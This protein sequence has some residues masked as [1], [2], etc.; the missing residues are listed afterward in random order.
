MTYD[1]VVVG[2]GL[3]GLT[4]ALRLAEQGQRVAVVARGVGATHLAPA[5]IDVLGYVDEERVESPAASLA[6]LVAAHPE[7]PYARLAPQVVA[8]SLEWLAERAAGLGYAGSLDENLLLPTAAGV[9]KPSALVPETMTGG[10]LRAGDRFLFVGLRGLK[11]FYA[12]YAAD[13]L[14]HAE[15]P[16]PV[17]ARAVELTPPLGREADV[18]SVGFARRFDQPEFRDWIVAA[19]ASK[20]EPD[21][22]IGFPAVLGLRS[23]GEVWRELE[24][25]LERRVFEVPT[26]PPSAPGIRLFEELKAAL[27]RAGGRLVVGDTAVGAELE[28][29]RVASLFVETAARPVSYAA[30]SFVLAS[31][32]FA[33]G[34]LELDSGGRV[35]ETV[36]GLPV[37]GLPE[38]G[39]AA[40]APG[41]FDAHP[42]ARAGIAVDDLL[43]PVDAEGR[44]VHENLH[45]AGAILAGAVP[46][47]EQSGS[48]ISLASGYAAAAAI[49]EHSG[50]PVV[51]TTP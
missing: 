8:A 18:S 1:T 10:D 28:G 3:A 29:S 34:G 5:A 33:S 12:S 4:A 22:R 39:R 7:H 6:R 38:P 13:N 15:L 36:F 16:M 17:S 20:A 47:R 24:H 23:A 45:A 32:G 30:R 25:R 2:A 40:F 31:G 11:D 26:L 14:A 43:R 21:E 44:P 42:L 49:L 27:R 50:V 9:P 51:E 48:G 41:Y 46:W 37:A 19:L 35:R